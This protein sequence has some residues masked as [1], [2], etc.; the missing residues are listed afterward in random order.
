MNVGKILHNNRAV[1]DQAEYEKVLKQH[2]DTLE[3]VPNLQHTH[4][5][6]V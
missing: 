6:T 1:Y 5:H 2:R 3:E 4:A